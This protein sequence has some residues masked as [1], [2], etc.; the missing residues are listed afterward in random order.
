M[1]RKDREVTDR[2]GLEQILQN[3]Q[4]CCLGLVD[5]DQPYIVPLNYAYDWSGKNPIFYMH[6]A[7]AGYKLDLLAKNNKVCIEIDNNHQLITAETAADYSYAYASFIGFGRAILLT[8]DADKRHGLQL[9]MQQIAGP[10]EYSLP[11]NLTNVAVLQVELDKF[12]GKC[13]QASC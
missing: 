9:L 8:S 6:C 4:V 1:R 5:D 2:T 7:T 12:S 11:K 10:G 13:N 3:S